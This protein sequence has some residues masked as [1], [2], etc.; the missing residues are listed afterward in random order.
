MHSYTNKHASTRDYK[1]VKHKAFFYYF[2]MQLPFV[3]LNIP[4]ENA[5]LRYVY[6]D[7]MNAV[8]ISDFKSE[9]ADSKHDF[10]HSHLIYGVERLD[11]RGGY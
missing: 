8:L 4:L 7:Q 10:P 11:V 1:I 2:S 5:F 3:T 6:I 9:A